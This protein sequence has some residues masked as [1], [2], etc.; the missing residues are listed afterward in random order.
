MDSEGRKVIGQLIDQESMET[1]ARLVSSP[2]KKG[3][4]GIIPGQNAGPPLIRVLVSS[5][6]IKES[7]ENLQKP[8]TAIDT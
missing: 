2:T 8:I 5:T 7:D 6:S 4:T 1:L 3:L